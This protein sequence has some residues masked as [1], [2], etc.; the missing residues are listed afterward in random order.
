MALTA[1]MKEFELKQ[2]P[3]KEYCYIKWL[4]R[5]EQGEISSVTRRDL[6]SS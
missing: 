3:G 1:R 4:E 2:A 6:E 5:L